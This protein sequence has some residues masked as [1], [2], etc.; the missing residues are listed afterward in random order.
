MYLHTHYIRFFSTILFK[1]SQISM[2]Q[3]D[4]YE[5]NLLAYPPA[6]FN[7]VSVKL[8]RHATLSMTTL[9]PWQV[10]TEKNTN[11]LYIYIYKYT[12]SFI[13]LGMENIEDD[14]LIIKIGYWFCAKLFINNFKFNFLLTLLP[15]IIILIYGMIR[16][17]SGYVFLY[18]II[19]YHPSSLNKIVAVAV[20][21][22]KILKS[23]TD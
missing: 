12:S 7:Y 5:S 15:F 22:L 19:F 17:Q 18:N 3:T 14:K 11:K 2:K 21:M 4:K 20:L 9:Q 1:F 13:I 10:L 6:A 23:E 8:Q 16:H